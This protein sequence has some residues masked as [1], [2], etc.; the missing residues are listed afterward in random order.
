MTFLAYLTVWVIGALI[1]LIIAPFLVSLIVAVDVTLGAFS[2]RLKLHPAFAALLA[3]ITGYYA[4]LGMAKM[5]SL[6]IGCMGYSPT[7]GMFIPGVA[8]GAVPSL[9]YIGRLIKHG[10]LPVHLWVASVLLPATLGVVFVA[11]AV[12]G[13]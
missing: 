2:F 5:V 11:G 6:L 9:G 12:L 10:M 7:W 1:M 8:V 3:L 13:K 4:G